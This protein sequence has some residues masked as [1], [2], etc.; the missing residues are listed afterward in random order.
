MRSLRVQALLCASDLYAH[1]SARGY[2]VSVSRP[3]MFDAC[4]I[5][6]RGSV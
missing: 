5:C 6:R 1:V 4:G 3:K 2:R